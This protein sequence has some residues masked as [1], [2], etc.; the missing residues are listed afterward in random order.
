MK[1]IDFKTYKKQIEAIFLKN[2]IDRE[3]VNIFFCEFFNCFVSELLLKEKITKIEKYKINR[4]IRKRLNGCPIQKIFKRAYFYGN[5][6][7][8]NKNVLCPRPETE[9]L[10]EECINYVNTISSIKKVNA[11]KVL[12][13][14]TGSGCIAITIAKNTKANVFASDIS[15]KALKVANKNAKV[16]STK[17]VFIKSNMFRNVNEKFDVIISNPPYIPSK[18]VGILDIEVK[19][20]DPKLALDGGTDGL[21]FYKIIATQGKNY[22]NKNGKIFLEVGIG[23]A[24]SVKNLLIENGFD[25][26]IKK[27]YNNIERIVVGELK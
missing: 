21:N 2:N 5:T 8:V 16:L 23:E 7:F 6:F 15:T 17:V 24:E 14:C 4:L 22:L 11:M 25:C 18:D 12:D 20:Y 1:C 10:T 26:Y 27:D 3:E 19:K 13:L 9:I